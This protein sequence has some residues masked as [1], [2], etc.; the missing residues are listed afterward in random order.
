MELTP[1][2]RQT[3]RKLFPRPGSP[4]WH[5]VL[6]PSVLALTLSRYYLRERT[7]NAVYNFGLAY[8][9]SNFYNIYSP[10]QRELTIVPCCQILSFFVTENSILY[11]NLFFVEIMLIFGLEY[12]KLQQTKTA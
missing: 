5:A 12:R 10:F 6:T 4:L 8:T 2:R 3:T 7:Y 9:I 1:M 11:K